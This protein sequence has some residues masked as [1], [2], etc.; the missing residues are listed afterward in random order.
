MKNIIE[1][2][3]GM[4]IVQTIAQSNEKMNCVIKYRIILLPLAVISDSVQSC[5]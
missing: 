2:Y 1:C 4:A 5:L 3:G